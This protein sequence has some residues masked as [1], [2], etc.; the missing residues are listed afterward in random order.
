M[1]HLT[2][3]SIAA[4][5]S[6]AAAATGVHLGRAT[7]AEIN[8]AYLQD[9]EVPFYSDLVP[10]NRQ[11]ADWAQVQTQEYQAAAQAPAPAGCVGCT[12][13]IDP[14]PRPDPVIARYDRPRIVPQR[15]RA[16]APAEIVIVEQAVQ[17]DWRRVERY[18]RYPVG[19]DDPPPPADESEQDGPGTR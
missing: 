16:E 19:H 17:P 7:I 18:S 12:W 4:G 6:I 3:L 15:E 2:T 1:P 13:P 10:G 8:P 14:M 9:P 5:L 11:R